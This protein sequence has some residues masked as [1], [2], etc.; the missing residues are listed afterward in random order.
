MRQ[1]GSHSDTLD[2]SLALEWETSGAARRPPSS[3]TSPGWRLLLKFL[4][5]YVES[6][7]RGNDAKVVWRL[8]LVR[9]NVVHVWRGAPLTG[10]FSQPR[11]SALTTGPPGF[12]IDTTDG[13]RQDLQAFEPNLVAAIS[14]YAVS[15][16]NNSRQR[17]IDQAQA[18]L[19]PINEISVSIHRSRG[20]GY[21]HLISRGRFFFFTLI[22]PIPGNSLVGFISQTA[23]DCLQV[24]PPLVISHLW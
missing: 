6:R 15:T 7:L 4:G 16:V 21:I 12:A 20:P 8:T 11:T 24:I 10:P 9:I 18:A 13:K 22:L 1:E 23:Q 3:S 19:G 14:T 2:P 5:L 17:F